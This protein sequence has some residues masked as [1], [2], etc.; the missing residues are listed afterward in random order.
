V[1]TLPSALPALLVGGYLGAGKTT[2]VNHLLRHAEGRR[3][4]VLVN[5]FGT[6]SIDADLIEGA[7]GEVLALAG[8]CVCCSYGA[9]LV[10]A[11]RAMAAREPRPDHLLIEASGVAL[12]AVVART[13]SLVAEVRIEG[14]LVLA[15]AS[16]L[17]ERV[18]ERYTGELI[19][20]QLRQADL[21][22]LN[23]LDRLRHAAPRVEPPAALLGWLREQGVQVPAIGTSF[24]RIDPALAWGPLE[25]AGAGAAFEAPRPGQRAQDL[26]EQETLEFDGPVDVAAVRSMLTGADSRVLRAK[27]VLR[28]GPGEAVHVQL[29]G[30]RLLIEPTGL[31]ARNRLA[32]I[33]LKSAA[34]SS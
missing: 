28:S 8:G 6:L 22:L 10:S 12:P 19:R 18:R 30:Q 9:D 17:T 29:V 23:H 14:I 34:P 31:P 32:I 7:A 24:G 1:N 25:R 5:D 33:R 11:L 16:T 3:I 2:L 4:A 20:D 13:A 21:V 15:D 27:G 26:F